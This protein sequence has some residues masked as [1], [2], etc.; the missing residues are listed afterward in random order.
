MADIT[1]EGLIALC[2]QGRVPQTE[3][4]NRDTATAQRQMGEAWA[5]LSAGCKYEILREKGGMGSDDNI[6]WIRIWSEGFD[7]HEGGFG[8]D[9]EERDD[10][11]DVENYYLPTAERL[12]K[13]AGKDWY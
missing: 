9:P 13:R 7:F 4:M 10:A 2:E 6:W 12:A 8:D 5:L 3:W 11:L 1:R